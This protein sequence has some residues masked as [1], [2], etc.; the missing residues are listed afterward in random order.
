MT[1]SLDKIIPE[2]KISD[3]Y[4]IKKKIPWATIVKKPEELFDSALIINRIRTI[5]QNLK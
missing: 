1:N 2:V 4:S 5:T 3:L